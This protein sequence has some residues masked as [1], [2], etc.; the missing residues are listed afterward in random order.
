MLKYLILKRVIKDNEVS[1]KTI[2][3]GGLTFFFVVVVVLL[4]CFFSCFLFPQDQKTQLRL[5]G[6]TAPGEDHYPLWY[7]PSVNNPLGLQI[8]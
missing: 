2:A 7:H 5:F 6:S 4:F 3:L 8:G 1:I